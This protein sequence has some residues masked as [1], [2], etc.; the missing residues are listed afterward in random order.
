MIK[1]YQ[2]F[3]TL[4][5]APNDYTGNATKVVS[6][7]SDETGLEFTTGASSSFTGPG[8]ATDNA[9]VRFDGA[10]GSLV[11]NSDIIVDDSENITG[12][13]SITIANTGLHVLDTNATHDLIIRPA[14]DLTADRTLNLATGD[15]NRTLTLAGDATFSG[16]TNIGGNLTT[17]AQNLTLTLSGATSVTL[18]TSG[19]VATLSNKVTDFAAPTSDFSMN[20]NKITNVD[21]PTDAQ[22]VAT[23]AYADAIAAGLSLRTSCRYATT[24]NLAATYLAGVLTEIGFGAL[25]VDGN[26]PIVGDRILVKDQATGT[27]NGIYTVTAV[28]NGGASYV[29]TRATDNDVSAEMVSGLYTFITGGSTQAATGWVLTTA[30]PITLDTTTLSFTQFAG[31]AN[32]T[33]GDGLTLSGLTF[34]VGAGSGITVTADTVAVDYT[35]V[36]AVDATLTAL[37]A[38]NSTPG[39]V[40]QTG[41]DTFTKRTLT[42]LSGITITDGAGTT[43]DPAVGVSISTLTEDTT[44]EYSADY[45]MTYDN[46]AGSLKK[47]LLSN[48]VTKALAF[49]QIGTSPLEIWYTQASQAAVFTTATAAV[50]ATTSTMYAIPWTP[51]TGGTLDR[52]GFYVTTLVASTVG[53]VGIYSNATPGQFYPGSLLVDSGEFDCSTAGAKTTTISQNLSA[54]TMYWFVFHFDN[55]TA[56]LTGPTLRALNVY[57]I[58]NYLGCS[59]ALG[60]PNTQLTLSG[61]TYGALPASFAA[62]ATVATTAPFAAFHR[63]SV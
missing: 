42:A 53:R 49:H 58:P 19:T 61:Q 15:A 44:P 34:N 45:L 32:Y 8:S 33:A 39:L 43:N 56:T 55:T 29:L 62:G 28:G 37:A 23:K 47:T 20:S 16:T 63:Y 26:T 21:D 24:V 13:N 5:D 2:R 41:A 11:Q 50:A 52:L 30:D 12:V 3:T 46:S 36:Q 51:F 6:V 54:G 27:Q 22:D 57:S 18:P 9:L 4:P 59:S 14:S 25:S 7:K 40:V 38:L 10:S 17:S 60:N 48:A 31:A 1:K 35:A